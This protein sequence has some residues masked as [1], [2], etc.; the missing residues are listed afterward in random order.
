MLGT[1]AHIPRQVSSIVVL[2]V[3]AFK[4]R[5]GHEN[6][7]ADDVLSTAGSTLTTRVSDT[8]SATSAQ[9]RSS[10]ETTSIVPGSSSTMDPNPTQ[11]QAPLATPTCN[12]GEMEVLVV[13]ETSCVWECKKD[14]LYK[15]TTSSKHTVI[16]GSVGAVAFVLLV[17]LGI[18]LF[19]QYKKRKREY[20]AYA[21]DTADLASELSD[22]PLVP[23]HQRDQISLESTAASTTV[24]TAGMIGSKV[25]FTLGLGSKIAS[26]A[27]AK[28]IDI[29]LRV[30]LP[31]DDGT[32]L[33]MDVLNR[34]PDKDPTLTIA[35]GTPMPYRKEK[36]ADAYPLLADFS[37]PSEI[38]TGIIGN[39]PML[40]GISRVDMQ[41]Q[42]I[43]PAY[44][45]QKQQ[46]IARRLQ[47]P[48]SVNNIAFGLPEARAMR[49]YE[50]ARHSGDAA[51][52]AMHR[53]AFSTRTAAVFNPFHVS[54]SIC[55]TP[56]GEE[57]RSV[58]SRRSSKRTSTTNG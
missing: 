20:A 10:T 17:L 14:P 8:P 33:T 30:P 37:H 3:V 47:R 27:K 23:T 28:S 46:S 25:L 16:G 56:F 29:P 2:P 4:P 58:A 19:T 39:Y 1:L 52:A 42:T 15:K 49:E 44:A 5:D 24:S 26:G 38:D 32:E 35:D 31:G 6:S 45:L 21:K 13:S 12:K 36:T 55:S 18:L 53:S 54:P 7:N 57:P 11:C 43:R 41:Q 9:G 40:Y 48:T 34:P 22:T 50:A 51:I